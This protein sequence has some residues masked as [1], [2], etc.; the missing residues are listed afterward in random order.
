MCNLY[1][2]IVINKRTRR[3]LKT[4]TGYKVALKDDEG[5]YYSPATGV[6]YKKGLVNQD[7][8][9]ENLLKNYPEAFSNKEKYTD[10]LLNLDI[11]KSM[12]TSEKFVYQVDNY[13]VRYY[14]YQ[15][16]LFEIQKKNSELIKLIENQKN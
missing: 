4:F 1:N 5:N 10:Y 12:L 14:N 15:T 11:T 9:K 16:I 13:S 3:P 2:G 6:T 8:A 7:F